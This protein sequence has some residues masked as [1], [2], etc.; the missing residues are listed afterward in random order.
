[1]AI[2][3]C[4][5]TFDPALPL[6]SARTPGINSYFALTRRFNYAVPGKASGE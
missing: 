4:C 2:G 6:L 5:V 1:M 3:K